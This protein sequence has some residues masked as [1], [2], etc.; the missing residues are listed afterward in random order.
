M[1]SPELRRIQG[2]VAEHEPDVRRAPTGLR[3]ATAIVLA[4]TDS[5]VHLLLIERT[6]RPRDPWSGDM[7]LPGGR[8]E[9]D[10]RDLAATARRE[11]EEEV[12]VVLGPPGGR[13]DDVGSR[14]ERIV[15]SPFV[16]TLPERPPVEARPEEVARTLWVPLEHLR[17]DAASTHHRF[18]GFLPLPALRYREDVIWGLTYRTLQC[19]FSVIGC[20]G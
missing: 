2:R 6:R 9:P 13:L 11:T 12:G 16:F 8:A 17:S 15:V 18:L 7:A 14:L 5:G 4:D 3:A 10:D 19:L 20:T 1:T